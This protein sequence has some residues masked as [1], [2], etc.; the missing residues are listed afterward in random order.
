MASSSVLPMSLTR[1]SAS[2]PAGS[3]EHIWLGPLKVL[4]G[5]EIHTQAE[6]AALAGRIK[7]TPVTYENLRRPVPGTAAKVRP[8]PG[9][10]IRVR[11]RR[12]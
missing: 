11:G 7:N 4:H 10:G 12:K 9:K 1:Y 2:V 5:T 6:W 8:A 3:P